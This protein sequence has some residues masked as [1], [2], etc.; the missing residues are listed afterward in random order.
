M[1]TYDELMVY[2][3]SY[4]LTVDMMLLTKKMDRGFKFTIGERVNTACVEMLLCVYRI[5]TSTDREPFFV[6]AREKVEQIRL[7]LRLMKDL[8]LIS[9]SRFSKLNELVESLSKQLSGWHGSYKH[10][11]NRK[12]AQQNLFDGER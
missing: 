4:D 2:K 1:A 6:K 11:G 10:T 3:H 7:L 8:H 9:V 5:N 12:V